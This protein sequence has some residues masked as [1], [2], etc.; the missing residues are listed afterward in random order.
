MFGPAG[1][2]CVYIRVTIRKYACT[3]I[4]MYVCTCVSMSACNYP[5][6]YR[7][8]HEFILLIPTLISV[9]LPSESF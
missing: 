6:L 4:P 2:S 5:Y 7:A 1:M 3:S 9:L 8:T